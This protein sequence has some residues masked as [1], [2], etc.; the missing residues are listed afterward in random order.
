MEEGAAN[1]VW[2]FT[3]LLSPDDTSLSLGLAGL[4]CVKLHCAG[5]VMMIA[6]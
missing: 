5:E 6:R 4:L 2:H 1:M 3:G